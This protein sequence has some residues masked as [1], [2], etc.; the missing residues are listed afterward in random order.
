MTNHLAE[1]VGD[2]VLSCI[3]NSAHHGQ[4]CRTIHAYMIGLSDMNPHILIL[5]MFGVNS[6]NTEA[7]EGKPKNVIAPKGGNR[8]NAQV[9]VGKSAYIASQ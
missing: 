4:V 2:E 3:I 6:K 1:G 7:Y 9:L 5:Q 8:M